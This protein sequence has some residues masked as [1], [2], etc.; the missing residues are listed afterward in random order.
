MGDADDAPEWGFLSRYV[1]MFAPVAALGGFIADVLQP[2]APLSTYI[3]WLSLVATVVLLLGALVLRGLRARLLP[4]LALAASFLVFSGAIAM[5]R[6]EET[7]AKGLLASRF[8]AVAKLQETLGLI[9]AD[10]A[11][12]KENTRKT[13]EAVGRVEESARSIA[14]SNERIALSLEAIRQ[15][16][17]GLDRAGGIIEN[18]GRPEQHYHNARLY[19]QRGDFGNARR[20]YN[21]FFAY[22]LDFIDPHI[23]YQ[24]FLKIQEGRAG[25]REIYSAMYD[26]DQ[27]PPMDFAR[28]LLLDAPQRLDRL[29]RFVAANPEFAPGHYEL[30]REY[31]AARKGSQSL[32]DKQAELAALER[33]KALDAEGKLV[34]YFI[35]QT[36]AAEWLDDAETRLKS[37]A[38][39]ERLRGRVPVTFSAVR[40][41]AD[42]QIVLQLREVPREIFYRLEGEAAFRSTGLTEAINSATGLK[43]PHTSFALKP[44]AGPTTIEIKYVDVG[45]EMRGPFAL[46]FDPAVE[47][48]ASQKKTLGSTKNGWLAFRDFDGKVLL[49]F[50][51][52]V[53]YRCAIDR[54]AYGIDTDATP[55]HFPL[56]PCNPKA[57]FTVGNAPLHIEVPASSRYASVRLTFKDGTTSETVR[58]DR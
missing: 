8:P 47:L 2:L 52:L 58:I 19:E 24:T 37:L 40:S 5:F 34:R 45:N 43:V 17:A 55:N 48:V 15:R 9:R 51:H 39:L 6:S 28:I 14:Q 21:A 7:E 56:E 57:P 31:S 4:L 44:G 12:I 36:A 35:D 33:F 20:S 27:R 22:K 54:I 26:R 18:A 30:S 11:E 49:Y 3:L 10:I 42:W 50:T 23:R 41:G 1:A 13:S 29:K 53:S 46:A 25:A 38:A 32:G 16:F